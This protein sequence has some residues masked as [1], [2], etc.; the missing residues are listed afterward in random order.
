MRDVAEQVFGPRYAG[1]R[2]LR[3]HEL[4]AIGIAANTRTLAN[5]VKRGELPTPIRMGRLLLFPTD[6]LAACLMRP[7]QETRCKAP[8]P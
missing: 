6:Q 8:P 1:R 5:L 4:V 7:E 2:Y 3:T